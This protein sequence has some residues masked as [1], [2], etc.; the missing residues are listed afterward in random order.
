MCIVANTAPSYIYI[1]VSAEFLKPIPTG[2]EGQLCMG[3]LS[4]GI[5]EADTL[6]KSRFVPFMCL[7]FAILKLWVRSFSLQEW[8]ELSPREAG[9]L[10]QLTET[11]STS[12][13]LD[14][15]SKFTDPPETQE[16]CPLSVPEPQNI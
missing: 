14:S 9:G 3:T 1:L 8:K 4:V 5:Q 12:P 15:I 16:N 7:H 6:L 13:G 2:V 11:V 10:S